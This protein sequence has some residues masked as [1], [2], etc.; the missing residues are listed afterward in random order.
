[1]IATAGARPAVTVMTTVGSHDE[2]DQMMAEAVPTRAATK[3]AAK[4]GLATWKTTPRRLAAVGRIRAMAKAGG[5]VIPKVTRKPR[6]A[7]GRTRTMAT[8]DGMVILRV[9]PGASRRGW[10]TTHAT[11]RAA[12]LVRRFPGPLEASRRGWEQ[13][14]EGNNRSRSSS[15]YDDDDRRHES[16]SSS[17]YP[18]DDRDHRRN[19]DFDRGDG[20]RGQSGWSGD[21]QGHSEASRRGW[22]NRR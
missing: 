5:T 16:R 8:A 12:R 17:R 11:A 13:G 14:H 4:D 15:R 2:A 1:M 9:T 19:D 7:V 6:A 22:Q 21:P 20:R 18:D 10:G 3:G